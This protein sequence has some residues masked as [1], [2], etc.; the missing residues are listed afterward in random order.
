MTTFSQAKNWWW[1]VPLGVRGV[2]LLLAFIYAVATVGS[3]ASV[4]DLSALIGLKSVDFW[5]GRWWTLMTFWMMPAGLADFLF[6]G[7]LLV[8]LG[9]RLERAWSRFEFWTFFLVGV[10]GS[11]M[12][13]VLINPSS[14]VALLGIAGGTW[15]LLAGWLKLFGDEPVQLLGVWSTTVRRAILVMAAVS[16][17]MAWVSGGPIL[18][19]L[20]GLSGAL[21]GWVYLTVRW[22]LNRGIKAQTFQSDRVRR[23]EL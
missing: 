3:K 13:K 6:N 20:T 21:A 11:G 8:M 16:F 2:L 23:L 9:G 1:M 12:A 15:G 19:L 7:L 5:H 10:A 18:D 4:F 14:D 22:R 17:V